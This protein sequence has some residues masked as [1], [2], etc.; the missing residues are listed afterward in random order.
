VGDRAIGQFV[1]VAIRKGVL[2][3]SKGW[4]V[5]RSLKMQ[6]IYFGMFNLTR[7]ERLLSTGVLF[8]QRKG[9]FRA[10]LC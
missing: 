3:R 8:L 7:P 10:R 4:H 6:V 2:A 1:V 9:Q 5:G